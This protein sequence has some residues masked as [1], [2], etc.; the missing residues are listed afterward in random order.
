MRRLPVPAAR[1]LVGLRAAGPCGPPRGPAGLGPVPPEEGV[2]PGAPLQGPGLRG[3][4]RTPGGPHALHTLRYTVQTYAPP[5]L[6]RHVAQE[7][8]W[9]GW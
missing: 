5:R 2:W 4:Q 9:V 8:E 6:G 3:P 1:Q 7:V